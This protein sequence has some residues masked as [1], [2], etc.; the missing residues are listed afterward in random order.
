MIIAYLKYY[1]QHRITNSEQRYWGDDSSTI[2]VFF[3]F[4][5]FPFCN[6]DTFWGSIL[7]YLSSSYRSWQRWSRRI[8]RTELILFVMIGYIPTLAIL[9]AHRKHKD[10]LVF[11]SITP[12]CEKV[13]KVILSK[14]RV[15][16][17]LV[18]SWSSAAQNPYLD[19]CPG[20]GT[21]RKGTSAWQ[22]TTGQVRC[23]P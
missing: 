19:C 20:P 15:T 16:R 8:L 5:F 18:P 6:Q 10:L 21:T 11:L 17:M 9:V 14:E 4:F 22:K 3:F 7:E 1:R 2:M 13:L 12:P 23:M